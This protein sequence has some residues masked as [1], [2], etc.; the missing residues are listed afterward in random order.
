LAIGWRHIV[1][2]IDRRERR[3]HLRS[4]RIGD[5]IPDRKPLAPRGDEAVA[6][7]NREMLRQ[8]GLR[9]ADQRQQ[10]AHRVLAAGQ[11][12]QDHQPTLAGERAQ[13]ARRGSSAFPETGH[14]EGRGIDHA[15]DI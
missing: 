2:T 5:A 7:Q 14:I 1:G 10:L 4:R 13:Q 15:P 12:A 11:L 9:H 8:G 3:H 6:A